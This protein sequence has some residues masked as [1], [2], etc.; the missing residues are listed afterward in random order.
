M[1]EI[2]SEL[3]KYRIVEYADNYFI[4]YAYLNAESEWRTIY[5]SSNKDIE[6]IKKTLEQLINMDNLQAEMENNKKD[7]KIV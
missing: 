5:S 6:E 3:N 4:Q 1:K 2:K 7:I